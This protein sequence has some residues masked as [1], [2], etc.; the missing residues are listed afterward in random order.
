M[1]E[2]ISQIP[3]GIGL[4]VAVGGERGACGGD[5]VCVVFAEEGDVIAEVFQV[6]A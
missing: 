5:Q 2:L 6:I 4:S 3:Q 1:G